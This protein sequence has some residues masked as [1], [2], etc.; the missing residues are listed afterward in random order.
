MKS[1]KLN[2]L[3]R[4][5]R[6]VRCVW[7]GNDTF[8]A[9]MAPPLSAGWY[10]IWLRHPG[11]DAQW[12]VR[13][14]LQGGDVLSEIVLAKPFGWNV[15][16]LKLGV[17]FLSSDRVRLATD[18]FGTEVRGFEL[19]LRFVRLGRPLA[20][21]GVV[22][23]NLATFRAKFASGRG[24]LPSRFREAVTVAARDGQSFLKTYPNWLRLFGELRGRA[25]E[26][27]CNVDV[28]TI[29]TLVCSGQDNSAENF[30]RTIDSL[31]AQYGRPSA[32]IFQRGTQGRESDG[33]SYVAILRAG[34]QLVPHAL[35]IMSQEIEAHH[36]PDILYADEDQLNAEGVRFAPIFKPQPNVLLMCSGTLST[37][38]WVV[39]RDLL[40]GNLAPL[41]EGAAETLR[42]QVWFR[43][44][45]A[46]G[47]RRTF[48]IPYVVTSRHAAT[49]PAPASELSV[50]VNGFLQEAGI[51]AAVSPGYPLR[52]QW[53]ADEA[54]L[55]KVSLLV[56]SK[57]EGET[58]LSCML[59][60]LAETAYPKLEMIVVVTQ[61]CPLT[62]HQQRMAERLTVHKNV[63][64]HVLENQTFNY[65]KANNVAASLSNG[66]C[67]CLLNDDV[68]PLDGSWLKTM[69][70]MFSVPGCGAVGPKL[71]YPDQTVQHGGII[72]GLAGTLE[73][74]HRNID[75]SDPGYAWRASLDQEMSAVTG[76]CILVRRSTFKQLGGLD[77][78]F[79][80]A[81]ND[82]DFCLRLRELGLSVIYAGSVEMIHHETITFGAGH[83]DA[84][85]A[86][87]WDADVALFAG[88]WNEIC[89]AD[90]FHNPNLSLAPNAE[91]KLAF[92]PR[93]LT[94]EPPRI[95]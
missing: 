1:K 93:H 41:V 10:L 44:F 66:E 36:F 77:E 69:V 16:G 94:G 29:A 60:I 74:A 5:I 31:A 6:S 26:H 64:I 63:R 47:A 20:S 70:A 9:V 73:H 27:V 37:G 81:F 62:P 17:F 43:A 55:P 19:W 21:I 39:R 32:V 51:S 80:T 38:V 95:E 68:S 84:T 13:L 22:L 85:T 61:N 65:S 33:A 34:E 83:Y 50:V 91:W 59:S 86:A 89:Q 23:Q 7:N 24:S 35:Q 76:A 42:L 25:G 52:L 71:L 57:L 53:T 88:R 40:P 92:P 75:R 12:L 11:S 8:S 78:G 2:F 87:K 90:P 4:Y 49:E 79:P 58:Q 54:V 67:V 30:H 14:R 48:R 15:F 72:L 18:P 28:A 56:A 46:D 45:L 3:S 82:V